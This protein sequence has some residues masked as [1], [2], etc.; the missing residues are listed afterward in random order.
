MNEHKI[1]VTC[2][3][4]FREILSIL[5][6]ITLCCL[7]IYFTSVIIFEINIISSFSSLEKL[8]FFSRSIIYFILTSS[9]SILFFIYRSIFEASYFQASIGEIFWGLKVCGLDGNRVNFK[10]AFERNWILLKLYRN[11][12]FIIIRI[13]FPPSFMYHKNYKDHPKTYLVYRVATDIKTI[14]KYLNE[15]L[16]YGLSYKIVNKEKYFNQDDM[17]IILKRTIEHDYGVLKLSINDSISGLH[18]TFSYAKYTDDP[19]STWF[20]HVFNELINIDNSAHF[21]AVFLIIR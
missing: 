4:K 21:S 18:N 10:T 20:E 13:F 9:L 1:I 7:I 2:E 6:D 12:L 17:K 15:H 8:S 14:R 11:F 5:T 16:F 19:T 3:S